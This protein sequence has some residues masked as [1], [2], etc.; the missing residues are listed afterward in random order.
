L[1]A[2]TTGRQPTARTTVR[3]NDKVRKGETA[4]TELVLIDDYPKMVVVVPSH[5]LFSRM[6]MFT[7]LNPTRVQRS[8]S[9]ITLA[10]IIYGLLP[11]F[12]FKRK[13]SL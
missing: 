11:L 9:M 10:V 1:I 13:V 12:L 4:P 8:T 3:I 2:L 7:T 5:F 6:K